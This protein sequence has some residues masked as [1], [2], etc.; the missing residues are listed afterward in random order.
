MDPDIRK[1]LGRLPPDLDA[2]YAELYDVLSNKPGEFQMIVFRNVFSWLLCAQRTL[3]SRE[4]LAAVS[5]IP[6]T[7]EDTISVSKDLIL[8]LCN[9]FVVFD[10]QLDTFRFAHLSVREF[11]E[12][13][14][15]YKSTATNALAAEICLWELVS[16]SPNSTAETLLSTRSQYLTAKSSGI[17]EFSEYSSVYWV[18]HYQLA[19]VERTLGKLKSI[20]R[21]FVSSG[22]STDCPIECWS[23][24]LPTFLRKLTIKW[25]LRCRLEDTEMTLGSDSAAAWFVSCA[26][27][28]PE[29]LEILGDGPA[30]QAHLVNKRGQSLLDVSLT[31]GSCKSLKI[32]L[33]QHRYEMQITDE[34][35]KA[36]AG[37]ESSGK[38]VMALLLEWRADEVK[39]TD[40]VIK[41]AAGNES[42]GKEVMALLLER[43]V[44]EVKITDEVVKAA[45]GN[46][47]SGKEII[48]LLLKRRADTID[49]S[50]GL[51]AKLA[52]SFNQEVMAL[53]LERR[54]DEVKITDE[55]VKEAAGNESS[56]KEVM[57]LL[58]E[59]RADEVK[60]TDEVVKAAAGNVSSGKE[61]MALLLNRR[62]DTIDMSGGLV[63]KLAKSFSQEVMALL[64][65]RRADE[66]KITDEVVKAAACNRVGKG[67]LEFLLKRD[68]T[69]PIAEE[70]VEAAACNPAGKEALEFLLERNPTLLITEE[71]VKAAAWNPDDKGALEF[72]LERNPSLLIT[73][74]VVEAA[75][76]NPDGKG[77]LE[78]LLERNPT[79]PI[80]EEVVKAAACNLDGKE[81]LEF[82]LERNPTL[83]IT[84]EVVKA[85][86][87]NP[88]GK[89][90][91]QFLLNVNPDL[92]IS[93]DVTEAISEDQIWMSFLKLLP[94]CFRDGSLPFIEEIRQEVIRNFKETKPLL[95]AKVVGAKE[96]R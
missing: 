39:I 3:K 23:A 37:N 67:V 32:L 83:P 36:A 94:L 49:I 41:A 57:A 16:M 60:I 34:A 40:E 25:E 35:V 81:A 7:S 66:V 58:L 45:A 90:A 77:A 21:L 54:A 96:N 27:D 19:A 22:G 9:N 72:L 76:W 65:E 44:D 64:L 4:F 24:R 93:E 13:R 48:A 88:A 68:P 91:V 33:N 85:A 30:P 20:L 75:A 92:F 6:Q 69:L 95:K 5:T 50:G 52:K 59:R 73:E 17:E 18:A 61:I 63:A 28:L 87:C 31:H 78:F 29:I 11:L 56:G 74:E 71:V 53:L 15:E 70:V 46:R 47:W 89:E 62:A 84:E 8:K 82:L 79:L 14:Q 2:L 42:S 86:A 26:F 55:V 43:R 80:T 10:A 1:V 12:K 38:E 51:V